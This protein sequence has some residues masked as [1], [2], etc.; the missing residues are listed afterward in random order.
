MLT[1]YDTHFFTLRIY[2]IEIY[3]YNTFFSHNQ[4]KETT[5]VTEQSKN[6]I[7]INSDSKSEVS[8]KT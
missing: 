7:L 1:M 2:F 5:I 4:M 3:A 8:Y 6:D